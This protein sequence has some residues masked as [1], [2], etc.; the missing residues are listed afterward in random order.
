MFMGTAMMR[1]LRTLSGL[2]GEIGV[3]NEDANK[4]L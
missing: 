1:S 3:A 4:R 2:T